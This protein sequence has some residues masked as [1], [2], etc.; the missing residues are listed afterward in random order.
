MVKEPVD[1]W[2]DER[3]RH[4]DR[5]KSSR[6]CG[7]CNLWHEDGRAMKP[8]WGICEAATDPETGEYIFTEVYEGC[9]DWE[10]R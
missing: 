8:G 3:A 9:M 5:M 10:P 4:Y 7:S 2:L 6:S 1:V